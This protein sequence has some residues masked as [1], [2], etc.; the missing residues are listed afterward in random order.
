MMKRWVHQRRFYFNLLFYLRCTDPFLN[1]TESLENLPQL[2]INQIFEMLSMALDLDY[3]VS[4]M[5]LNLAD[6]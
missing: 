5:I 1:F 6:A 3:D 4:I 2:L